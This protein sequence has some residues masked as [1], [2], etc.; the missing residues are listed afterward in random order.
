MKPCSNQIKYT[1]YQAYISSSPASMLTE[2]P[3]SA[4]IGLL[5]GLLTCP[6]TS[7][8]GL[9]NS[10]GHALAARQELSTFQDLLSRYPNISLDL[11]TYTGFTVV[12]PS[13]DAFKKYNSWNF[14]DDAL[15]ADILKYH[16]L[17]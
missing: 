7:Q 14:D 10:L 13:N 9:L 16:I 17:Q 6:G 5:L 1:Q 3:I 15:V 4:S 11:P 12:A 8:S 2:S